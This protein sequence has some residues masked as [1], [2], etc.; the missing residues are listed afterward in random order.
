MNIQGGT[1]FPAGFQ[2]HSWHMMDDIKRRNEGWRFT[3]ANSQSRLSS[4]EMLIA[5]TVTFLKYCCWNRQST[6]RTWGVTQRY[7]VFGQ[8][9]IENISPVQDRHPGWTPELYQ[10]EPPTLT[11]H[12]PWDRWNS[13]C[14]LGLPSQHTVR[15]AGQLMVA[16]GL[17]R[18]QSFVPSSCPYTHI[19]E[20][21]QA[22][23][24]QNLVGNLSFLTLKT[25]R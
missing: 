2:P 3:T 20:V 7:S 24:F 16:L 11:L 6:C 15:S 8:W 1:L 17:T 23:P 19:L 18:T 9:I 10:I 21:P 13:D 5:Y 4:H 12:L 25:S 22:K 14:S